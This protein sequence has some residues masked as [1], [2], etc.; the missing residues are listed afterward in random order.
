MFENSSLLQSL[1]DFDVMGIKILRE[2]EEIVIKFSEMEE[3]NSRLSQKLF[4][5]EKV[6]LE[7]E[8]EIEG[9]SN[10]LDKVNVNYESLL[11]EKSELV[12]NYR[13]FINEMKIVQKEK[14]DSLRKLQNL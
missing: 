7:F 1:L 13:K 5:F 2:S 14:L 6:S 11:L 3:E 10:K 12:E 4:R 9:F 8:V